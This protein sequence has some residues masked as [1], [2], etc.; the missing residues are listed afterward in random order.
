[1]FSITG[2]GIND[3]QAT[4]DNND[5]IQ[6]KN[7]TDGVVDRKTG[8][9]IAQHL[10]DLTT[11][12][13]DVNDATAVVLGNYAVVGLDVNAKLERDRV[14]SIKYSVSEAMK[15]DPYG[16]NAV[17]VA[18]PDVVERLRQMGKEIKDGRPVL[19]IMDE[20]AQIV[21]RLMPDVP[22]EIIDNQEV[23]P[24]ETSDKQLDKTEEKKLEKEQKDQSNNNK[25]QKQL[26]KKEEKKLEKE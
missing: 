14:E 20:L 7:T 17:V 12:V 9:E 23:D 16:A 13:P 4:Q 15:D 3:N 5:K 1:M 11:S 21:G 6:V 24:T 26:D 10:V 19:G 8:Q 18:D 25:S 22:S 2:C